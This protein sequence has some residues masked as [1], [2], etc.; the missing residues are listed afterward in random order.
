M[1][2]LKSV[3]TLTFFTFLSFTLYGQ[4]GDVSEGC[5][6]LEVKF[7]APSGSTYFWEFGDG[8]TS[9]QRNPTRNYVNPGTYTV[10]FRNSAGGTVLATEDI[11]VYEKPTISFV[12]D[13]QGGCVPLTTNLTNN[14]TVDPN[15][16]ITGFRWTFGDGNSGTGNPISHTYNTPG[17]FKVSLALQS[18]MRGCSVTGEVDDFITTSAL[19]A[20]FTADDLTACAAPL[21]VNFTNTTPNPSNNLTYSWD[22]GNGATS[23]LENPPA[24]TYTQEGSY[25]VILSATDPDGC[26]STFTQIVNIGSPLVGFNIL[27]T[28]CSGEA[29]LMDNTS[30]NGSYLWNFGAGANPMTSTDRNPVVEFFN[31]QNYNISLTVTDPDGCSNDTTITVFVDMVFANFVSDPVYS[32]NL[33]QEFTY[34]PN[35]TNI[36]STIWTFNDMSQSNDMIGTFTVEGDTTTYGRNGERVINTTLTVFNDRGCKGFFERAD[37]VHAPNALFTLDTT[38]GCAPLTVTFFDS[39]S[40]SNEA[41]VNYTYVWGDGAQ[42][43]YTNTDPVTHTY[44]A[45]GDYLPFLI[46][47]NAAG[48]R[49]TSYEIP[50]YVGEGVMADFTVSQTTICPG[51]TVSFMGTGDMTIDAWH[52]D[53]E[54][55]RLSH[56][57]DDANPSW[58]FESMTGTMD[59]DL[60]VLYNGC[61]TTVSKS[62]FITVNGPIAQIDY[63]IDCD[64]PF[65]V[66]FEDQSMDAT[67]RLWTFG[68]NTNSSIANQTVTYD[69]EGDYQVILESTNDMSGCPTSYDTVMVSI[70]DIKAEFTLEDTYCIGEMFDMDASMSNGVNGDCWKGYTWFPS[71]TRPIT[72]QD[73]SIEYAWSGRDTQYL[74]LIVEDINGCKD[75]LRDTTLVIETVANFEFAPNPICTPNEVNFTD[76]STS[77]TT[78]V[79]WTWTFGDGNVD[80]MNQNTSHIY[81]AGEEF[82]LPDGTFQVNLLVEDATECTSDTTFVL[83]IYSPAIFLIVPDDTHCVGDIVNFSATD[84]TNQGSFLTYEWFFDGQPLGITGNSGSVPVTQAGEFDLRVEFTEDATGCKQFRTKKIFVQDY[85]DA[86]FTSPADNNPINCAGQIDFTGVNTNPASALGSGAYS[87]DPDDGSQLGRNFGAFSHSY[88][89]GT[90]TMTL[91]LE[92]TFGCKD[93]FMRDYTFVEPAGTLVASDIEICPGDE[94][95]FSVADTMDVNTFRIDYGDG[96]TD[97][98]MLSTSHVF[99]GGQ[100]VYQVVLVMEQDFGNLTCEATDVVNIRVENIDASFMPDRMSYCPND[101][102]LFTLNDPSLDDP[103]YEFMWNF[104]D[105]TGISTD[106]NPSH[107]YSMTGVYTV[108]LTVK[109]IALG[110][111]DTKTAVVNVNGNLSLGIE[112]D[113]TICNGDFTDLVVISGASGGITSDWTIS[114]SPS[115]SSDFTLV[116]N[117][118]RTTTYTATVTDQNL[119]MDEITINVIVSDTIAVPI[120]TLT[121]VIG[122][123][124]RN[125]SIALDSLNS[126]LANFD[127][128]WSPSGLDETDL[129]KPVLT[130]GIGEADFVRYIATVSND[131]DEKEYVRDVRVLSLPNIFSPN[132]D[133]RNANFNILGDYNQEDI[134][135]FKIFNRW[136]QVIYDNDNP[137][138]GWDGTYKDKDQP[139]GVYVY[140]VELTSGDIV[141]GDVTLLR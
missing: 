4:L 81:G 55:G 31:Q 104:G 47:E 11:K 103:A 7:T 98:N 19:V 3:F 89:R 102:V 16:N 20:S 36:D 72:T 59:V 58:I 34:T 133:S 56:C 101:E 32:C 88:S 2:Y 121:K 38:M 46:I 65:D 35:A 90:Y 39:L 25:N 111:E 135:S 138:T 93:T 66:V 84:Q 24:Q 83:D 128:M 112:G 64:A 100:D 67:T 45:P 8:A 44:T 119:C 137:N 23:T 73:E 57:A 61:P 116:D 110:C 62:D 136:G 122:E 117:P 18:D 5:A 80:S 30:S 96:T 115:V 126:S 140:V 14:S 41:I 120:D 123:S 28:L 52:F 118:S 99:S 50:V 132:G 141:S 86:T 131:C 15:I 94:V 114:W 6:T 29:I 9:T 108:T 70:R 53:V 27:D 60:T 127:I 134:A 54:G 12:G 10:T 85:P 68:N 76:L 22:L 13:P 77:D 69:D 130:N 113:T 129:L 33:P 43:T 87:W 1:S 109:N 91:F 97:E 78:L 92:T 95:D 106:R 17:S 107:T 125:N 74:E 63:M 26:V 21:T 124:G 105:N 79:M 139:V 42:D 48:C 37:T 51:D 71:D 40:T 82:S 75:T 49:D